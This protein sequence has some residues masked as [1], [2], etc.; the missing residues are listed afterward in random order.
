MLKKRDTN[1]NINFHKIFKDTN[2]T[3]K[4]QGYITGTR[5]EDANAKIDKKY[6][7]YASLYK[8]S[9]DFGVMW[10]ACGY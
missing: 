8:Y 3:L 6:I 4:T 5:D 10:Y 2:Y 7:D 1:C 9:W